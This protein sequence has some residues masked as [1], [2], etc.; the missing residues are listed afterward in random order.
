MRKRIAIDLFSG[1]GGLTQG[2][3]DAGFNVVAGAEIRPYARKTYET[4]NKGII[5]F[6]DVRD[7]RCA[8][9]LKK[10]GLEK[11][12]LDL[13]AACPPCQ[14]FS[15]IRTRNGEIADDPRNEL[16]FEVSR[17]VKGLMPKC[18]LIE[19][20][21][22]LLNDIRLCDFKSRLAKLGY[23]FSDGVLDAQNFGV[24]QRRKR[25]ILIAS[26]ADYG[27]P[28]GL[29]VASK[30]IVSVKSILEELPD[31][32]E[33]C[34]PPL[35]KIRQRLSPLVQMRINHIRK[36]RTELPEHLVLDCHKESDGGFR[37]VYGRMDYDSVAPTITQGCTNPSKGRFVHPIQNRGIT[38]YEAM[39]LQ[40]FPPNYKF[41]PS[42]GIGKI[43][44]MIG[45]AF[46]PPM[47]K[48]QAIHI[49]NKLDNIEQNPY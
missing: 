49:I 27:S 14:G 2:L 8:S 10:I 25:M 23:R 42:L 34:A 38:L 13:L 31:P 44:S 4:N 15:S 30:Q 5:A 6:A 3:K 16:I 43:A 36:N 20:V 46:P 26:R 17:L 12:E 45:E 37:D 29:P 24:P 28:F 11:G 18:V 21:P 48:A 32:N 40:G 9:L 33:D 41:D 7:I 19:N 47:A 35:H 1:C 39:L 22:R